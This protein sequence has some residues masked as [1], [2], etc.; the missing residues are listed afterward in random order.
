MLD[1]GR[2]VIRRI[3]LARLALTAGIFLLISSF[4][5]DAMAKCELRSPL[6]FADLNWGSARLHTAIASYIVE[7]GY[8]CE[9]ARVPGGTLDSLA[10]ISSGDVDIMMEVWKDNVLNLWTDAEENG[11]VTDL[12]VNFENA[13]QG[14]FVPRYLIEGDLE[15]GITAL[16]PKLKSVFDLKEYWKV[17]STPSSSGSGIFM[18][19]LLSWSCEPVNTKKLKIY[20]LES[21]FINEHPETE[22]ELAKFITDSYVNGVPF[23][24]YYWGPTWILGAYDLIRLEEPKY[25]ETIWQQLVNSESSEEATA[26][27]SSTIYKGANFALELEAPELTQ[28]FRQYSLSIES[29]NEILAEQ[30]FSSNSLENVARRFLRTHPK[31]LREWVPQEVALRIFQSLQ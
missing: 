7:H 16:A 11:L 19:C 24:S 15:R 10:R 21:G 14:W 1:N 26:Y 2:A 27:P 31:I 12:G 6:V 17:F 23:V 18:N 5:A 13:I 28:F 8:G 29:I 20:G 22:E 3:G 4:P 30:H 9:T 25:D